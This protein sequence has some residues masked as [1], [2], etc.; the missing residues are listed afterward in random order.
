MKKQAL[1]CFFL[2]MLLCPLWSGD[3]V[4][5][6]LGVLTTDESQ[7]NPSFSQSVKSILIS[8]LADRSE[9]ILVESGE[10]DIL[11]QLNWSDTGLESV[12]SEGEKELYRYITAIPSDPEALS[13]ELETLADELSPYLGKRE[14]RVEE[15]RYFSDSSIEERYRELTAQAESMKSTT[16]IYLSAGGFSYGN[17]DLENL[18]E[19]DEGY[20]WYPLDLEIMFYKPGAQGG[21]AL[22]TSYS[23]LTHWYWDDTND[24]D[25]PTKAHRSEVLVGGVSRIHKERFSAYTSLYGGFGIWSS[26]SLGLGITTVFRISSGLGLRMNESFVVGG[27]ISFTLESPFLNNGLD[28]LVRIDYLRTSLPGFMIGYHF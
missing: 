2:F 5:S 4:P 11:L 12:L 16:E 22:A 3:L 8:L 7:D 6:R 21:L 10:A 1:F 25:T 15:I 18:V 9:C 28:P 13:E 26:E 27:R 23:Y 24:G 20:L 17:T 14:S 19:A